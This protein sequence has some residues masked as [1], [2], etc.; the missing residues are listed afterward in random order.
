LAAVWSQVVGFVFLFDRKMFSHLIY[1]RKKM[2]K[3]CTFN[4]I[5]KDNAAIGDADRIH[6][7]HD[8][9]QKRVPVKK[10]T[11]CHNPEEHNLNPHHGVNTK[12]R[13]TLNI[14]NPGYR[15]KRGIS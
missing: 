11:R 15:A 9:V 14:W 7:A 2:Y 1:F 6:S 3:F 10:S 13:K 5:Y 4:A 12:S 8:R